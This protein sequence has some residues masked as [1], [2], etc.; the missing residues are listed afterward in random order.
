MERG[1]RMDTWDIIYLVC[2]G[3]GLLYTL[4]TLFFGDTVSD[5]LGQIDLP[6]LQPILLVSALTAFGA[7]GFLLTRFTAFSQWFVFAIAV[8][9]GLM[10]AAAA[11]FVW[12]KPMENAESSIGYSMKQLEGMVGEVLTSIPAEGLGEVLITMVGGT[13]NHMA[14]SIDRE[15]IREG[16]RVVVIDVRDHVLYVTPFQNPMEKESV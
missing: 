5:L 11:Y 9:I 4:I 10:L 14:A 2:M 15:A 13:T 3:T 12:V 7:S 6:V 16:T 8:A 1:D